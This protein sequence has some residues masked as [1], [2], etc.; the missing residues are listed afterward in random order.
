MNFESVSKDLWSGLTG[1]ISKTS[2]NSCLK[3][4]NL[5][6]YESR[7]GD[8]CGTIIY[9]NGLLSNTEYAQITIS[10]D[11]G[12]DDN[13]DY[14]GFTIKA[15]RKRHFPV[16]VFTTGDSTDYESNLKVVISE[17]TKIIKDMESA[18]ESNSIESEFPNAWIG[19]HV[20]NYIR[21]NIIKPNEEKYRLIHAFISYVI[22]AII[23]ASIYI[24]PLYS[25]PIAF[26]IFCL[27]YILSF[28]LGF[29]SMLEEKL[30]KR[31]LIFGAIMGIIFSWFIVYLII[32]ET[33]V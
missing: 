8:M 11:T 16:Q 20:G 28:P 13:D 9:K 2:N 25:A 26:N 5:K 12:V 23:F 24:P 21:N 15:W 30:R 3:W 29:N 22:P 19:E 17:Y 33:T 31:L 27:G 32:F 1:I 6:Y 7:Q 4:V 10:N 14:T 18:I